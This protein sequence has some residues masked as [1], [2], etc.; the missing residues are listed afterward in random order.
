MKTIYPFL[1]LT[2]FAVS[3]WAQQ[4]T[5]PV[6]NNQNTTDKKT[7]ILKNTGLLPDMEN[8]IILPQ[9]FQGRNFNEMLLDSTVQ[10]I[11]SGNYDSTQN[12]KDIYEWNGNDLTRYTYLWNYDNSNWNMNKKS[13][14][15]FNDDDLL[16]QYTTYVWEPTENNW[17][18]DILLTFTYN[19]QGLEETFTYISW[20]EYMQDWMKIHKDSSVYNNEGNVTSYYTW[21]NE[22]NEWRLSTKEETSYNSDGTENYSI[23]YGWDSMDQ[24]WRN[25]TKTEYFYNT[26]TGLNDS[27]YHLF[28]VAGSWD[29][30]AKYTF[31]YDENNNL[32]TEISFIV[33]N[34]QWLKYQKN[35]YD[36]N[37]DNYISEII[38]SLWDETADEWLYQLKN[39]YE[40]NSEGIQLKSTN[41]YWDPETNHWKGMSIFESVLDNDGYLIIYIHSRWDNDNSEW[42]V[43]KKTFYHWSTITA[44][45]EATPGELK[46]YPNPVSN[47]L[48]LLKEDAEETVF[49]IISLT[50]ERLLQFNVS[51]TSGSISLENLPG[52]LFFLQYN[53]NGEMITKKIIKQ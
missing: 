18:D 45:A 52:G 7:T 28:W 15:D 9:S 37:E 20:D 5:P 50:G 13:V 27:I 40:Y 46:I 35:D 38:S 17:R 51:G 21:K 2:F 25:V 8:G 48:H 47:V 29:F 1:L 36:Y 33:Q 32:Q 42:A 24:E 53:Q 44:I 26:E 11:F 34:G 41:Y 19:E 4:E 43:F 10:Y 49:S 30:Q 12:V 6:F 16:T 14:Y 23:V 22:M 39:N 3:L 31:V